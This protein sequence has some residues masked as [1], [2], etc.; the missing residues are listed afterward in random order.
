MRDVE[1][2]KMTVKKI[3]ESSGGLPFSLVLPGASSSDLA[4]LKRWYWS[5]ELA[6]DP[7]NASFNISIH[8]YLLQVDGRNILIDTCNGNDKTRS[9]PFANKLQS[10]YL[11]NLAAAHLCPED[12]DL[13]LCTHL[14][15]DHVGWNTRLDSGRWVPTFPKARYMFSRRDYDFFG[16]QMQEAL[17]REAFEDSVLPI[18]EAGLADMVE[19]DAVVHRI[20]GDGVW[21]GDAAGHS[22]GCVVVHAERGGSSALFSGD[23][24]H[25][26]IQLV[27]PDLHFFADENPAQAA[28][29]RHR[30]MAAYA[31][32][33]T[34]FFPA[35]FDGE[36][37]GRIKRDGSTFRYEFLDL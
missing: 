5:D 37:A 9:V 19:S 4:A 8:S 36:S 10:A 32:C 35:H 26:P 30:L 18:V 7:T 3:F 23:V 27:R 22:P 28:A 24:F 21:L 16:T 11:A 1:L 20:I 31:D 15:C 14:H 29:V 6:L 34:I 2:G 17:H 33:D 25:H 13:V 12:I